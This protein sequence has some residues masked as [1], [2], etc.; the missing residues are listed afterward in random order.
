LDKATVISISSRNTTVTTGTTLVVN[1]EH[2]KQSFRP[3]RYFSFVC[4][5]TY[6]HSMIRVICYDQDSVRID[7]S[8]QQAG[9]VVP[10][11]RMIRTQSTWTP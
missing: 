5:S 4:E 10:R 2:R 6:V 3:G 11:D 7:S 9:S 1:T 8:V